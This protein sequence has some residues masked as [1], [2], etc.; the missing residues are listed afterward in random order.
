MVR[1][2]RSQIVFNQA[3]QA[4]TTLANNL[5]PYTKHQPAPSLAVESRSDEVMFQRC[6][7]YIGRL[8][9]RSLCGPTLTLP[10]DITIPGVPDTYGSSSPEPVPLIAS[11]LS[12]P[13]EAGRVPLLRVLPPHLRARYA[14]PALTLKQT[15][16]TVPR[17]PKAVFSGNTLCSSEEYVQAIRRGLA[18]GMFVLRR[19]AIAVNNIFAVEK[20]EDS[21]RLIVDARPA[22]A[23][24]EEPEKVD[25]P[26]PDILARVRIPKGQT[27]YVAKSDA[28]DFFYQFA[29]PDWL[30]PIFALP[31]VRM[32][33]VVDSCADP[34]LLVF[35]CMRVLPMGWAHSP[36]LA[37]EAHRHVIRTRT[38]L[39][40][41]DEITA[42]FD[43]DVTRLRYAICQDDI[44]FFHVRPDT[45][46][47]ALDEY[48]AGM[49]AENLPL[50]WKKVR[51]ASR[52]Q[53]VLG[54]FFDG[55]R[56]TM[57]VHPA[58][59][60]RIAA[61]ARNLASEGRGTPNSV[62][63]VVGQLTYAA[64]ACRPALSAFSAVYR[65][66]KRYAEERFQQQVLWPSV[67]RELECMAALAP[68]LVA[69]L[70]LDHAPLVVASDASL[71][72]QGVV[73]ARVSPGWAAAAAEEATPPS[74]AGGKGQGKLPRELRQVRWRTAV[75][76][77]WK[78][79]EDIA[80]LEMRAALTAVQ[81]ASTSPR[82]R[83]SRLLLFTDSAAVAGALAK[84]RSS[85]RRMLRYQRRISA[86]LLSLGVQLV[87]RWL[88]SAE[89]PADIP[90][91][92]L[93]QLQL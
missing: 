9:A 44:S 11:R 35:P 41:E 29:L 4:I 23:L 87:V 82:L 86:L 45:C 46:N 79:Q 78:H 40:P 77:R 28:A 67:C 71:E 34:D 15:V 42:G 57:G 76:S 5:R 80:V 66:L 16:S 62:A 74:K 91:R 73:Y 90:S 93:D 12:L 13:D 49:A 50:K 17:P 81:W 70:R 54:Q 19:S 33:D 59:L 63:S 27:L 55:L 1:S 25:F 58:K 36:F 8:S 68:L 51:R 56:G 85:S 53:E 14:S 7:A 69:D 32:G 72:G 3:K 92:Q 26:T 39:R 48:A 43:G 10:W 84:G 60:S 75:S 6:R 83:Y 30:V 61:R 22:N 24:F 31:P 37:Q 65:F 2:W 88:A 38:S 21:Q 64:L 18:C 52:E 20:S 47:A 89:N